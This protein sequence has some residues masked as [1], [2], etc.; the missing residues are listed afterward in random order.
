MTSKDTKFLADMKRCRNIE[1][2][3]I[4][5]MVEVSGHVG[6][7]VGANSS[8]NLDVVFANHAKW[9][10]GKHNCHPFYETRYFDKHGNVV[11]DYR[12]VAKS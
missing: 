10:K 7:I 1:F 4:G 3:F 8:A 5:Q 12:K 11:A 9:G 2:A 6:T